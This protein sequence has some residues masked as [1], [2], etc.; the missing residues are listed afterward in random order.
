MDK[1]EE[2]KKVLYF[3]DEPFITEALARS[4]ELFGW[5]VR[6]VSKI[7]DLFK[8]LKTRQFDIV[9]LDIMASIPNQ[10]NKYVNFSMSEIDEM[11]PSRGT[12]VG[13]ILA[14]KIWKEVNT[15]TPILFLSARRNPIPEE[16]ELRRINCAYLRKPQLAKTIDEKLREL[17]NLK[18][19]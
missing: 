1:N 13:I 17:L 4:L 2:K 3:D 9:I 5:N 19:D 6:Q 7:D 10:K 18:I 14:K 12:N 11:T 15:D 16:P 8:E